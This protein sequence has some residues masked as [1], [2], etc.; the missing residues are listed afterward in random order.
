MKTI[1]KL[2][3]VLTLANA[4]GGCA[5]ADY[6]CNDLHYNPTGYGDVTFGFC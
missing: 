5:L 4:V 6:L 2:L 3:L 1:T